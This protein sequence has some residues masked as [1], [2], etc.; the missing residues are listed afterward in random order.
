MSEALKQL[1][2]KKQQQDEVKKPEA[3][4]VVYVIDQQFLMD[5]LNDY[6]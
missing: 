1:L 3:G 5:L 4:P 2:E 6:L